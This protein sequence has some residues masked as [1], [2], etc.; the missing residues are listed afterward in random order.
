MNEERNASDIG[1]WNFSLPLSQPWPRPI[2]YEQILFPKSQIGSVT[3]DKFG[4][5]KNI[6]LWATSPMLNYTWHTVPVRCLLICSMG[7]LPAA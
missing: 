1:Q 4:I 7:T 2:E 3:L 5:M 6:C